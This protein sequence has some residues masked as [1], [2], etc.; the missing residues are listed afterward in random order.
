VKANELSYAQT[1]HLKLM[2]HYDKDLTNY[3]YET[4]CQRISRTSRFVKQSDIISWG[5]GTSV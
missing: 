3:F 2:V 5:Q 1:C 4:V